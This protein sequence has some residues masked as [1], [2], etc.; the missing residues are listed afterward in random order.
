EYGPGQ[1]FVHHDLDRTQHAFV[2]AFGEHD[3][4]LAAVA[5]QF[6]GHRKQRLHERPGAV[7]ELL[8]LFGIAVDISDGPRGDAV[9]HGGRSHRDVN[10]HNQAGIEGL[11]DEV[12]RAERDAL[13]AIGSRDE[14]VL[15]FLGELANGDDGRFF[16]AP[17]NRGGADIECTPEYVGETQ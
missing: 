3:A 10:T 4:R 16:H 11:G 9:L 15:L 8:Q 17:S 1:L 5:Y 12:F 7:D 13:G 14:V 2:F 6:L